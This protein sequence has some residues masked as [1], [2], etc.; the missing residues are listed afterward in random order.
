MPHSYGYRAR[1]R[2]LFSRKFGEHGAPRISTYLKTYHVGDHVDI[3][4][5]GAVQKGMPFKGYHGRTG[6]VYNV[7]KS[8]VGV[9]VKKVVGNRYVEKKIN[10][11]IE[12]V[13]P[14]RCRED[15]LAR[16]KANSEAKK[17]AKAT[18]VRVP[19]L[20]R[21]PAQPRTAHLVS[22]SR[23]PPVTVTPVPYEAL[24]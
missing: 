19:S 2:Q 13:S 15:F 16:V 8:A 12:H 18:G 17:Q 3:K 14:S 1:T 20:K 5:N 10:V 21:Q 7:T 24:I 11:R 4:A 22:F 9:L 6:V 23:N